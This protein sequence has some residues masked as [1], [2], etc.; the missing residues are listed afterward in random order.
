MDLNG[1]HRLG[2]TNDNVLTDAVVDGQDVLLPMNND[3]NLL[4]QYVKQGLYN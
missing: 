1:A 2:L 4:T 3:W